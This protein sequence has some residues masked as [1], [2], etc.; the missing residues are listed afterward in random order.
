VLAGLM[1]DSTF[2]HRTSHRRRARIERNISLAALVVWIPIA[3]AVSAIVPSLSSVLAAALALTVSGILHTVRGD[4]ASRL[5]LFS[6]QSEMIRDELL[7]ELSLRLPAGRLREQVAPAMPAPAVPAELREVDA[8]EPGSLRGLFV[9]AGVAAA[10]AA[11]AILVGR[12]LMVAAPEPVAANDDPWVVVSGTTLPAAH[13]PSSSSAPIVADPA[14]PKPVLP[15]CVCERA[16]SPLW[17]DGIPRLSVVARNRPGTTSKDRPSMYPEI[18][19]V[20]NTAEDLKDVVLT[21]DFLL[22]GGEGR[23]PRVL[24]TKDLFWEGRLGPGKAVK[25]RVK[26]RGDDYRVKSFV[27]GLLGEPGAKPAPADA[28]YEL[29]T[30]A[31]TPA[32]RVHGV[33]MLAWMGDSRAA[34]ALEKLRRDSRGEFVETLDQIGEAARPLRVCAV[35]ANAAADVPQSLRVEACV[36]NAGTE[37]RE[38]PLITARS[39]LADQVHESRWTV[40]ATIA[41]GTGVLT[42]GTVA[43]PEGEQ[44]DI[45]VQLLIEP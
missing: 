42:S 22:G 31:R 45:G 39:R 20:N 14:K 25:W 44:G 21:V 2:D 17:K 3:L 11:V 1:H 36:F 41:P 26:G 27:A 15:A 10:A 40:D 13:V 5:V 16:D 35:R 23:K 34:E 30:T 43:M 7:A 4:I 28:F 33:T 6:R 9:T 38:S 19:V 29:S 24:D 12:A 8:S 37:G 18:A 32:V